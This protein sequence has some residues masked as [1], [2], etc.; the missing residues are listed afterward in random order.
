MG[1]EDTPATRSIRLLR[2]PRSTRSRDLLHS[3]YHFIKSKQPLQH[4]ETPNFKFIKKVFDVPVRLLTK[5]YL[6]VQRQYC[7]AGIKASMAATNTPITEKVRNDHSQKY[8]L[9]LA[10]KF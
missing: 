6:L 3:Y 9:P 10:D 8:Q 1:K 7:T 2:H 5:N 4:I